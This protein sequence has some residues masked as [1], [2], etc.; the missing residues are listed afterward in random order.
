M[1]LHNILEFIALSIAI[2]CYW[3]KADF[4]LGSW[5]IFLAFIFFAELVAKYLDESNMQNYI[6]YCIIGIVESFFYASI[7]LKFCNNKLFKKLVFIASPIGI[8]GY[9]AAIF[10]QSHD[11]YFLAFQI[12]GFI[13]TG[14]C[15]SYLYFYFVSNDNVNV[16]NGLYFAFSISFFFSGLSIAYAIFFIADPI[17]V[18]DTLLYNIIARYL[19]IVLY[20]GISYELIRY[21]HKIVKSA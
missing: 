3:K 19:S 12:S 16:V 21:S 15:L 8:V 2:Y 4:F 17:Y 7:F 10:I 18:G 14:I 6:V 13:I 1:Y 5:V 11:A 9:L 20:G